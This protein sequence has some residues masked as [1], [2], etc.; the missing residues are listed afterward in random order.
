M[1]KILVLL[2]LCLAIV[3]YASAAGDGP[4]GCT[5]WLSA[6]EMEEHIAFLAELYEL[7]P[8]YPGFRLLAKRYHNI[9]GSLCRTDMT[10]LLG[11]Y[12]DPLGG[13]TMAMLA[14]A[15]LTDHCK[16]E[17]SVYAPYTVL[18]RCKPL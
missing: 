10:T 16:V 9:P 6:S 18:V 1:M 5:Q 7:V 4:K 8:K 3:A 11:D 15:G 2:V 14:T 13:S 17:P 12:A